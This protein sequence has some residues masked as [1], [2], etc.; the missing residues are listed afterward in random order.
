M[1]LRRRKTLA[2]VR[3]PAIREI[4]REHLRDQGIDPDKPGK[5]PGDAFKGKNAPRM[6]SGVPIKK[7]RMIEQS[8]TFRPVSA[9]RLLPV[10]QAGQ[11]I[12]TS[13]TGAVSKR[14]DGTLD[15]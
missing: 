4:L 11:T 10:R 14:T 5:I 2:K 1:R 13:F 7:V 8:Q 12:I 6:P 15:G 9:R 3:D